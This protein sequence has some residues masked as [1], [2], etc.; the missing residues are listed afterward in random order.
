[1]DSLISLGPGELAAAVFS[2]IL[3]DLLLSGDNAAVIGMAICHLPPHIRKR[4]AF[5][6]AMGA[7]VLRIIFTIFATLLLSIPYFKVAG[8]LMLIL[9]TWKLLHE[10]SKPPEFKGE[11]K[12]GFWAAV[13]IIL[14]ADLSMAFDNVLAVAGAARGE[15]IL[16]VMGLLLSIPI[17]VFC[18]TWLSHIM[19]RY[20]LVLW[21][22]G[23]ILLHTALNMIFTDPALNLQEHW[24]LLTHIISIGASLG[25]F[26]TGMCIMAKRGAPPDTPR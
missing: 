9:I 21:L 13:G 17:L 19:C 20:P 5:F 3:L 26:I 2:I 11:S 15:P 8:G 22:G 18:S 25:L 14:V 16:V 1:M 24:G 12:N 6:G 4:A 7:I 10:G 23:S